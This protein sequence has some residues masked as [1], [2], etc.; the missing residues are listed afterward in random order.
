MS[1]GYPP[2]G[3][4]RRGILECREVC[5][6]C[7]A[8]IRNVFAFAGDTVSFFLPLQ[9]APCNPQPPPLPKSVWAPLGS[10][11]L[12][13]ALCITFLLLSTLLPS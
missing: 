10:S 1:W 6:P 13:V 2:A 4:F 12:G 9:P 3:S 8:Q 7:C 5:T 11:C